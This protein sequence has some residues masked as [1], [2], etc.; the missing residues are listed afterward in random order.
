MKNRK[1]SE[2]HAHP[3][4]ET[5]FQQQH[6]ITLNMYKQVHMFDSN[7]TVQGDKQQLLE[8]QDVD[9]AHPYPNLLGFTLILKLSKQYLL[10]Y[11]WSGFFIF[12]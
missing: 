3:L 9:Y 12:N 8:T 11:I 10:V 5:S 7:H 2:L 4:N 1:L 6:I